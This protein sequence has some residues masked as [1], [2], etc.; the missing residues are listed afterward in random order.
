MPRRRHSS[1]AWNGKSCLATSCATLIMPGPSCC[2][3]ATSSTTT[4]DGTAAPIC[5]GQVAGQDQRG[6]FVAAGDELEEQVRGVLFEGQVADLI[7]DDQPVAAQFGEL[8]GK[9]A[10]LVGVLETG[11]PVGGGGEQDPLSG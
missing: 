11:E 10:A 9:P 7:D 6:V 2:P 8:G 1:P 4:A 3:G 5:W